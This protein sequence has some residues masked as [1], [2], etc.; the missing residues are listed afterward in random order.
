[1]SLVRELRRV[2]EYANS[3]QV[4]I[5]DIKSNSAARKSLRAK[6]ED[7]SKSGSEAEITLRSEEAAFI[8]DAD[9]LVQDVNHLVKALGK[10]IDFEDE[11]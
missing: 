9:S 5:E 1:M 4:V 2:A 10:V 11:E 3:V 6:A 7:V 8:L